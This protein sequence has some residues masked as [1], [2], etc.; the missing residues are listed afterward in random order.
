ML[1]WTAFF[2]DGRAVSLEDQVVQP[3]AN[4]D[5]LGSSL[6]QAESRLGLP[7]HDIGRA[8]ASFGRSILSGNSRFDR[9][10]HGP[11]D[12]LTLEEQAGLRIFRQ[13]GTACRAMS[14][15]T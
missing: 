8:V 15:R 6:S 2:W 5:E 3:I 1:R 11:S 4:P 14:A 10:M 13:K 7:G 9:F 12:A